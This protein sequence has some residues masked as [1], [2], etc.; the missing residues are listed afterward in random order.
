MNRFFE[1]K[2]EGVK[3]SDFIEADKEIDLSNLDENFCINS[4]STLDKAQEGDLS[5]FVVNLVSGNK[6]NSALAKTKASYCLMKKQYTGINK[7][8][9][10][11]ISDEPYI[12]FMRLCDKLFVKKH[13]S[14]K[15]QIHDTAIVAK[16]VVIEEGVKIGANV[17]IEDFVKIESGVEIKDGA[18]IQ[19]GV[20]IGYNCLIGKNCI[21][22]KNC[23]VEYA[24]IGDNCTIQPN[25]TIGENGFGY[26][27]DRR[28]GKNEKIN[29]FGYVKI[30][31]N[32]EIGSNTCIDRGVFEPTIIDDN[33]KLDNLIQVAHN[34]KI[35]NGTM[36]ASQTGIAGS[37]IIGKYCMIGGHCGVAGHITLSDQC[38]V[39][40]ATNI[41]KSF[42]KHSK[43]IGTPGEL[44]HIWVKNYA[45]MQ[46]F[47]KKLSQ[48]NRNN[49]KNN[50]WFYKLQNLFKLK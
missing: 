30:G 47:L 41:S 28:S 43:I 36:I 10:P 5:F 16:N 31:N 35:G 49:Y 24:E 8:I 1:I 6:Y 50:S 26:V 38:I 48:K 18:T 11:I 23:V 44:Y 14:N 19:S 45:I 46:H 2:K 42:A 17:V 9:K 25:A 34:V 39:H 40:G 12:T 13:N 37:A 20:K 3:K 15:T 29:H 4:I 27:F 21:L 33:V 32:V 22:K 7:N